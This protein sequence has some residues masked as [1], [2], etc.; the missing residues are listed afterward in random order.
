MRDEADHSARPHY[1]EA[2]CAE[3]PSTIWGPARFSPGAGEVVASGRKRSIQS[4]VRG[5]FLYRQTEHIPSSSG[6]T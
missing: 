5:T 4:L 1:D 3:L 2:M 6:A